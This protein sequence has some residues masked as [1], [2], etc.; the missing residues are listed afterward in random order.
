MR[1]SVKQ[2]RVSINPDGSW[3]A[4]VPVV[5]GGVRL[6]TDAG[7]Q[8]R[9]EQ[10]DRVRIE[11]LG[12]VDIGRGRVGPDG[13]P[14]YRDATMDGPFKDRVGG[15]EMWIGPVKETNRYFVGSFFL[16][17]VEHAGVPTLRVIESINGYHDGNN[18]GAFQA[19]INKLN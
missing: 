19:T 6:E 11:V 1:G 8:F 2:G 7:Q 3:T 9:L 13:E 18:Q 16:Q 14:G 10:G 4:V 17:Q 12:W 5:E 15:V